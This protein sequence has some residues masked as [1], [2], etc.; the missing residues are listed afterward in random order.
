MVERQ[1][2]ANQDRR[3]TEVWRRSGDSPVPR[4]SESEQ[5]TVRSDASRAQVAI[6]VFVRFDGDRLSAVV[7]H[8][9]AIL[10]LLS[11]LVPHPVT[12]Q[13][14]LTNWM[15]VI[16]KDLD[17]Q[18]NEIMALQALDYTTMNTSGVPYKATTD[19]DAK[20]MGQLYNVTNTFID[21]VQSKQAYPQ[22]KSRD[23]LLLSSMYASLGSW[24]GLGLVFRGLGY[25]LRARKW[26][27]ACW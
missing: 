16:S 18:L 11:V 4:V 19:F 1:E 9:F 13:E 24:L 21:F 23:C 8:G 26:P 7:H 10:C 5:P 3:L 6:M 12:C 27:A 22:G 15:L 2:R 20:G 25:A 17:R 14:T